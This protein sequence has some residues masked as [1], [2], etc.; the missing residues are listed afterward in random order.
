MPIMSTRAGVFVKALPEKEEV[1]SAG[2]VST[3]KV[4]ALFR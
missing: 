3:Y 2:A 1:M 4:H